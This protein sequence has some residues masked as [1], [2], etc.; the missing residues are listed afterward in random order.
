M[1][2][3]TQVNSPTAPFPRLSGAALKWIAVITM[4]MDHIG[5][6]LINS[7][8]LYGYCTVET[9]RWL[10]NVYYVLRIIG[11]IAF[12]I[13]CYLLVEGFLHT[14]NVKRYAIKLFLFALLSEIPFDLL[15]FSFGV[16][17][18][19]RPTF[20]LTAY[21]YRSSNVMFTLLFGLL[22]IM[23][24]DYVNKKFVEQNVLR[25]V[26]TLLGIALP[27]GAAYLMMTDY[28]AFGVLSIVLIYLF[29]YSYIASL[30]AG[31]IGIAA[32]DPGGILGFL[33]LLCYN[34][35]RGKQPKY[36][37]YAFYPVHLGILYVIVRLICFYVPV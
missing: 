33:V 37:F 4:L 12:P 35:Q 8:F 15:F 10:V 27:C 28:N 11:R 14:R 25:I 31:F 20:D 24:I 18:P 36:F 1:S 29:R 3:Y 2:L 34:G 32:C 5:L 17:H 7:L 6:G 19:M 16:E 23:G 13:Y 21:P 30:V 26:L 9:D 22:A